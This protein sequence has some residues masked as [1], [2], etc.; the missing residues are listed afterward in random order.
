[1]VAV[2]A[3][4]MFLFRLKSPLVT[5]KAFTESTDEITT[6]HICQAAVSPLLHRNVSPFR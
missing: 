1:M 2:C 6:V 3:V 5:N 4:V